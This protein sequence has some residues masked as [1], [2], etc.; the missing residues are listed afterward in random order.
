MLHLHSAEME[1]GVYD[2]PVYLDYNATSP[3]DPRVL[4]AMLPYFKDKF[5]NASSKTHSYGWVAEAAVD[6]S[7]KN[8][9]RLINAGE[10]E[11]IFTSGATEACNLAVKGVYDSFLSKG[12]HIITCDTEHRAIT[13][14]YRYLEMRGARVTYLPVS[15]DGTLDIAKL[16]DAISSDTILISIMY[17]NNETGVIHPVKLI[18]E[19]CRKHKILF[20]CDAT[21]AIGK[22]PVDVQND[23]IDLLAMS[24]HKFYGPKGAGALYVRRRGPRARVAAQIHGGAQ[25]RSLRAGTLNVPAIAGMGKAA[26]I[27]LREMEVEHRR[28]MKLRLK[29]EHALMALPDT[30]I[31]AFSAP[32][33]PQTL[34]VRFGIENAV[35]MKT[36]RTLA[37]ATGSACSSDNTEVSHVLRAMGLS[38]A[39]ARSSL[40]ISFGKFSTEEEIDFAINEIKNAITNLRQ[41][42]PLYGQ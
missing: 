8:I 11:I 24:A 34:N 3:V 9:S 31:N 1:R 12:R 28:Q 27:A 6:L 20:F 10:D 39:M 2:I 38:E 35:L 15:Q 7:R 16:E 33:L 40:R 37:L 29:F 23:G 4:E 42:H 22:I 36:L 25:E 18:S 26:E 13:D 41:S 5:G 14:T 30:V 21:Q 19:I 32:R 17:A